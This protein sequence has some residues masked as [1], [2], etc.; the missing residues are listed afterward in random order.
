MNVYM[1]NNATTM[2]APEVVAAMQAHWAELY[3]SQEQLLEDYY[4]IFGD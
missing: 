2:T 4:A 3:G 1:D